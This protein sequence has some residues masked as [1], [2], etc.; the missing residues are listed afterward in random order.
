MLIKFV[1]F[2]LAFILL[3]HYSVLCRKEWKGMAMRLDSVMLKTHSSSG[4]CGIFNRKKAAPRV[5]LLGM[6]KC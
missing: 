5:L 4:V 2:T 1:K 3:L 6:L